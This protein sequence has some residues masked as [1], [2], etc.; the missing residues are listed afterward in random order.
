MVAAAYAG[1]V[2]MGGDLSRAPKDRVPK[3]LI[4]AVKGPRGANLDRIQVVKGWLGADGEANEKVFDVAWSSGRSKDADGKL[5]PVGNTVDVTA[6]AY[7]NTIG[8]A[9]LSTVW[10]DPEFDPSQRA[11]YYARVLEIPTPRWSTRDAASLG[12]APPGDVPASIQERAWT[13]PI[14]YT[15]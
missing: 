15:P 4:H 3:L 12:V 8:T 6:A 10:G 9:T 7:A 11:F 13:S 5:P 1:G 14:W 2:P